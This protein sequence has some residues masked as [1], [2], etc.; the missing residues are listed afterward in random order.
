MCAKQKKPA[1]A[2]APSRKQAPAKK[3]KTDAPYFAEPI[4]PVAAIGG[5]A[6]GIEAIS[7]FLS[8]LQ[9]DL[10]I[11]YVIIQHLSPD[12]SSILPSLLEKRTSMKVHP[13]TDGIKVEPNN[14][15]VIPPAVYMTISDGHLV[16]LQKSKTDKQRHVFDYFL[17]SLAPVYQHKAIAIVLSGVGFDGTQ[18]VQAI[19]AEGGISFAQDDSALFQSMARNAYESGYIDFILSPEGIAN[20]LA[21]LSRQ[22]YS[23]Q[24][25]EEDIEV[26]ELAIKR[27]HLL[28]HNRFGV[29]FAH[30]KGTTINRRILRRMAL[31]RLKQLDPYIKLLRENQTE[32]ELLYRDL[33]INV[34][35]FFREPT[36]FIT[37]NK[38]IFPALFKNR[39]NGEPLRIWIPAC[40]SGEEACSMAIS[41]F[42]FLGEKAFTTPIQIFATDLS[43]T[44]IEKARTGIYSKNSLQ[45]VSPQR[46]K[47]FFVKVDGSYQIIKPIRDI[48]I[49][50]THN[51]LKD[52]PFSRMDLISCQNVMIYLASNAQ[53]KILLAFHYAL[54][55][56]G[57]LALGKSETIGNDT[58]LFEAVDKEHKLYIKKAIAQPLPF[59]FFNR[60]SRTP[61]LQQTSPGK[62]GSAPNSDVD[63]EKETDKL[64]LSRYVPA[65]VVVNKDLQIL[66]FHGPISDYLQPAAGKASLHLLKMVK[67]E[68][69][70]ELRGLLNNAKKRKQ[71]M[72]KEGIHLKD[73]SYHRSIRIEVTPVKSHLFN[74]P[75]YLIVF[76]DDHD[77][78]LQKSKQPVQQ[79][80]GRPDS[81]DRR[82]DILEQE[83]KDA[84]EQMKTMGEEFEATREELQSANEEVLSSNEELQSINEE[85]ETSKEEL[86]S[87]NEELITINEELQLRNADLRESVEYTD[88]IVQTTRDPLVV[89]HTDL[90]VR[91]ANKAFYNL[92]N[93][94][95]EV[96]GLYFF[97]FAD[98]LLDVPALRQQLQ[99]T[100]T[101]GIGFQDFE[102]THQFRELGEKTLL[103][104]AMRMHGEGGDKRARI[105]LAIGNVT[106]GKRAEDS[107]RRSMEQL[108]EKEERLRIAMEAGKMGTLD[109]NIFTSEIQWSTDHNVMFGIP[110]EKRSGTYQEFF[111]YVHPNDREKVAG[112]LQTAID[113]RKDFAME[114]RALHTN[115]RI[116]WIAA[117]GR[118]FY[119]EQGQ[120]HR[121]IG[122]VIDITERKILENQKEEFIG[123]A[124]HELRTPVTSIKS[125]AQLLQEMLKVK[126]DLESVEIIKKLDRQIDRLSHLVAD[127]LDITRIREGQLLLHPELLDLNVLIREMAELMQRTTVQHVIVYE[128]QSLP[129][130]KADR[131]RIGQV[132][133]NLIGN[134][135]KY[136]PK[137][138]RIIISSV[139]INKTVKISIKD[140]GIGMS[141]ETRL[142]IFEQF[143]RASDNNVQT[144]PGLGLGLFI[145][146]DII[147]KHGGEIGVESEKGKGTLVYFTLPVQPA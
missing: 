48:C 22:N 144:Y 45:H 23:I 114:M 6:G 124:S 137:G 120:A 11:A 68:L 4:F 19:K 86:Q 121:M 49:F 109:W 34:T 36:L 145:A 47:Q 119:N 58:D 138:Q 69:V 118:P 105:L 103:F 88:A 55:P 61:V 8:H 94:Q 122:I 97:E 108:R 72:R 28:L 54:K 13:V 60:Q 31:N 116:T 21:A 126:N 107:L 91:T 92:F 35:C 37:L 84:R 3:K 115:G 64:L 24:S 110:V 2:K 127:L 90:R 71:V 9:P 57:Y 7:Q 101:K 104:N 46:L 112:V 100:V 16:L 30:Y 17:L 111:Q 12:H 43:E 79:K 25:P 50:A 44:A 70:F 42:E 129:P 147:K 56:I 132:L 63:I 142:K 117:F 99:E 62:Q 130:V 83:L 135:I 59:D 98:G 76:K 78:E 80:K 27:I 134:A 125:Y 38:L 131:E 85:L 96:D 106:E 1:R 18:G 133:I 87:T 20:E 74:D 143:F 89:L 141:E 26:N 65:S 136:S 77:V 82:I 102:L 29:D 14:V 40:S 140:F 93:L 95:Q 128:L 53:K 81:K 32:L 39:K 75:Y 73:G 10:G 5:S 33:L 52:P 139:L 15:Y 41:L 66:R 113:T 67:D 51:L 146:S 123:I